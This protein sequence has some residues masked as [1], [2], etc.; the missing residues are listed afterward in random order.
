MPAVI[1]RPRRFHQFHLLWLILCLVFAQVAGGA[2]ALS[3]VHWGGQGDAPQQLAAGGTALPDAP[4]DPA[5]D[6]DHGLCPDC[7]VFSSLAAPL[8]H[9]A[10]PSLP[11]LPAVAPLP[12]AGA[13][14]TYA[15]PPI[16]TSRDPPAA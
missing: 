15:A 16:P 12:Q 7:L 3:H 11:R 13:H 4:S 8:A 14:V 2:H 9:S 1:S 5:A 6:P 10:P